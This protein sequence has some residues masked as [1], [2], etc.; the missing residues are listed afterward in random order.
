MSLEEDKI[1]AIDVDVEAVSAE[2][3]FGETVNVKKNFTAR[4]A[5]MFDVETRGI[6]RVLPEDRTDTSLVTACT[7]WLSSNLV[8][9]ALSTGALSTAAF[10]LGWYDSVAII[11]IFTLI[12]AL[13]VA[14][15]SVLCAK[16]GLRQMILT[17]FLAG[18]F[19]ARIYSVLNIISCVGWG[20]I[21]VIPAVELLHM[22]NDQK[23]PPWAGCLILVVIT[24]LI[25]LLG[26]DYIH[27]YE[28]YS[29]IPNFIIFLILI[30]RLHINGEFYNAPMGIGESEISGAITYA[31]LV[32]GFAAGW[33]PSC[34]DYVIYKSP[35]IPGWKIFVAVYTGI[36]F[37]CLFSLLLG[38]ACGT[39]VQTNERLLELWNDS[40]VGGLI[41]GILVEN[42]LHGFGQF[43]CVILGLST[44]ANNLPSS[45]SVSIC[46]QAVS[47]LSAKIPR[48]VW[49][50]VGNFVMLGI[51]IPAYYVFE[52]AMENFLDMISYFVSIYIGGTMAEHF[53]FRKGKEDSYNPEDCDNF[54]KLPLGIAGTF[55]FCCG[56]AGA[57]L[58]MSETWYVGPIAKHI[59][60]YG[61]DIGWE[62]CIA[63]TFIGHCV[64]R[65]FEL[66]YFG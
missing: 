15:Y 7:M 1:S 42:S 5:S 22:V 37:P 20:A 35:S 34:G 52:E 36:V 44:I 28:K 55:A 32:F 25:A 4:L 12:G 13:P 18:N 40:S 61:G 56:I 30:A 49:C 58:G 62:L 11:I 45:Y 17:R 66:K 46:A 48:I 50:F 54:Y 2:K 9:A 39:G 27:V 16:F 23:L 64:A 41:Y 8:I 21:N 6:E 19:G 10:G 24:A 63:F 43:C 65:P 29:W 47:P 59:G 53:V 33:V 3:E 14:L 60:S 31:S 57:V 51:C 38:A 26:Y